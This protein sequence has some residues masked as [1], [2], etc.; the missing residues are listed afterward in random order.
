ME[1]SEILKAVKALPAEVKT[2]L[3]QNGQLE[4]EVERLNFELGKA[5]ASNEEMT[6]KNKQLEEDLSRERLT[7]KS[8]RA[9]CSRRLI[10]WKTKNSRWLMSWR[11]CAQKCVTCHQRTG[12]RP[13]MKGRSRRKSSQNWK[14]S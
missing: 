5:L 4:D 6:D 8:V 2:L 7:T 9:I 12:N 11:L 10:I 3:D 14:A 13:P 1:M